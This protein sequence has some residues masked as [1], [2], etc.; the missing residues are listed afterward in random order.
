[1]RPA[2]LVDLTLEVRTYTQK[3]GRQKLGEHAISQQ[4]REMFYFFPTKLQCGQDEKYM[5]QLSNSR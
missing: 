4:N 2:A 5:A 3:I 1:M